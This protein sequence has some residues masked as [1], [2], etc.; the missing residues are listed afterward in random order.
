MLRP[1][2]IWKWDNLV[3]SDLTSN[4]RTTT[5]FDFITANTDVI[6]IGLDR[7]FEG[8]YVTLSTAGN[9]TGLAYAYL[10]GTTW[11]DVEEVYDY[12]FDSLDRY[13]LWNLPESWSKEHFISTWPYAD[14]PPDSVDRYWI[15]VTA[16]AVTT[17]A[18]ISLLRCIPFAMYTTP[19]D[20]ATYLG[21][22]NKDFFSVNSQPLTI[23][24]VEEMI[25]NAEE[26]IDYTVKKSWRFNVEEQEEHEFN[27]S[28]IKLVHRDII[29]VYSLEIWDGGS[30]EEKTSGRQSDF[31]TV[32]KLGMLYFSRYFL[33]PARI[34]I[35]GPYGWGW[36]I[37]EFTFPMRLF[38]S[39]G[40]D[41]EKDRQFRDIKDLATKMVCIKV[42]DATN[43]LALIPEGIQGGMDLNQKVSRWAQDITNKLDNL[44]PMMVF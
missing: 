18:T 43:Y 22:S 9:Y 15:R 16:S 25:R 32:D 17:T 44:R 13:A 23:N 21:L 30:F 35:S 1:S 27:L 39:W 4:I 38:Y 26:E 3:W 29:S 42:L 40:K 34:A 12:N 11:T 37:G 2:A 14:D 20:V 7:R 33:L 28:G 6:Y 24:D 10:D 41:W 36:G 31:F 5:A 19:T 8:L